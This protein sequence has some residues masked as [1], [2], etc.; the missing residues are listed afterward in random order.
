MMPTTFLR[1]LR[2]GILASLTAM[3]VSILAP[4]VSRAEQFVLFDVT[5]TFT[6]ADADSSKP[7]KSHYYV[8]GMAINPDRPRD[9]TRPVDYRNGTVHIRA[10][11]LEKPAGGEPTTWTLCYIPNKGKGNGYGC[12]GTDL[13]REKGVY[14]KDVSMK[15]FW[16]NDSIIW[17]EGI[18]QMDLVIKDNSSGKGHAHKRKDFEKFFPT[19][20]RITM[21]QVS[22]GSTYDPSLVPNLPPAKKDDTEKSKQTAKAA[23]AK[24]AKAT[25][26]CAGCE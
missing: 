8:R 19:K 7:S 11:V 26:D 23:T 17:S 4:S 1:T 20:M 14:E 12:T 2:A 6:K 16:E 22:A 15:S 5:F 13:Y 9:W 25:G 21:V 10:E 24:T 18:K 3:W